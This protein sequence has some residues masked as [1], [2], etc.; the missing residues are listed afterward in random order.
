[1]LEIIDYPILHLI[2]QYIG[3]SLIKDDKNLY[4]RSIILLNYYCI[5]NILFIVYMFKKVKDQKILIIGGTGSLGN[6][7]T[8]RYYKD[9]SLYLMSRDESKHWEMSINYKNHPF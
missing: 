5:N 2:G 9:N 4:Q 6:K 7:L 8:D 1:M 3:C